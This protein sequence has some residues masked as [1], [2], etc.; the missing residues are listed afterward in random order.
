MSTRIRYHGVEVAMPDFELQNPT[1][2]SFLKA[3]LAAAAAAA[4]MPACLYNALTELP[5]APA[6]WKP[7][8]FVHTGGLELSFLD[9][10]TSHRWAMEGADRID[11]MREIDFILLGGPLLAHRDPL[12]KHLL[13]AISRIS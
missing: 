7:F 5:S 10:G 9:D 2:R 1:R 12:D 11:G 13:E 8:R 3:A 4:G 6:T